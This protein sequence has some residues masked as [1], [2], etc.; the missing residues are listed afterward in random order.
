MTP[1]QAGGHTILRA[2]FVIGFSLVL[3]SA[4][5][6]DVRR[7]WHPIGVFGYGTNL[8]AVVMGVDR[9]SPA[10]RAGIQV[11]DRL[12]ES[13]MSPQ[14]LE[15]LLQYPVMPSAGMP[16]SFGV[17]HDGVRR[18]V[19]VVSVP[20]P[21]GIADE[22]LILVSLLG[23]LIFI[24]I[25]TIVVLLRPSPLTWGFYFF[26]LTFA[27]S[28]SSVL[29]M[30]EVYGTLQSPYSQYFALAHDALLRAAG[31]TG[32]LVFS[33]RFL[34][35]PMTGWRLRLQR[36]LPFT[37]LAI[38]GLATLYI[39]DTYFLGRPAEAVGRAQI[40]LTALCALAA[41]FALIDTYVHRRGADRQR[42]RWVVLGF[43]V[44]LVANLAEQLISTE[45]TN[46]PFGVLYGLSLFSIIAP[47][48]VAYAIVKHRV[49]DVTFV[50]SR[51]LVYGTLT[52]L[53]IGTFAFVNWFVGHV[54]EQTGW[55][56]VSD[57]GIAVA[58]G[59]WLDSL[60]R[61]VDR[62]FE[63]VLFRK[64]HEAEV[65]LTRAAAGLPHANSPALV[66]NA[67]V[68]EPLEGLDLTSAALFRRTPAGRYE[69]GAAAQ[70]PADA[71][72]Y[73]AANDLLIVHLQG[74]RRALRLSDINWARADA[75]AAAARPVLAVPVIVRNQLDAIA[76]YGAHSGGEDFDPDE[77]RLLNALASAA[78]V[79]FDHLESERL[80]EELAN[81]RRENESWRLKLQRQGLL[82][83]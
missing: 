39:V 44:A 43:T 18:E 19:T 80:R 70:W 26:C 77:I 45:A 25:G 64:R 56:L 24:A 72:P 61:R 73:L 34:Q 1:L 31:L 14:Q 36:A 53:F 82:P 67:M 7:F 54:L 59:F 12:D 30:T 38:A 42:I 37:F 35:E 23:T 33:L 58:V 46:A 8:D 50:V 79:A 63:R 60:H 40:T 57:I 83:E 32:L 9:D 52:T 65:R 81:V 75:P 28:G 47:V 78:G 29:G 5:A 17:Y 10:A 68:K 49:I 76:M 2:I 55:A 41:G 4:S 27:P 21:M 66:D 13:A 3:L 20:E 62:F 6:L 22:T 71:I 11:G 74:E 51:T 16:V 69:L 15:W 48:A